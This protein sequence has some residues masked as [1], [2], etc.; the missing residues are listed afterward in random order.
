MNVWRFGVSPSTSGRPE[1]PCRCKHRCGADRVRCGIDGCTA[2][3]Q[4]SSGGSVWRRVAAKRHDCRVFG[5]AQDPG[6]RFR[7]PGLALL[8]RRPLAPGRDR[9]GGDPHLPAQLRERRLRSLHCGSDGV[10]GRGAPVT[11]L[12]RQRFLRSFRHDRTVKPRDRTARAP[13]WPPFARR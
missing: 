5:V 8:D 7:R 9:L 6:A 1:M 4:S 2:S 12:G 10:R 11:T 13:T 3:G